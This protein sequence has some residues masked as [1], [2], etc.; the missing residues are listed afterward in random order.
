M[1]A[2]TFGLQ[3][4][5][6]ENLTMVEKLLSLCY[7]SNERNRD[8]V[9]FLE[10]IN[11]PRAAWPAAG[12]NHYFAYGIDEKWRESPGCGAFLH[13]PEALERVAEQ[14]GLYP[15]SKD[16]IKERLSKLLGADID[17]Y[18]PKDK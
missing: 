16:D 7:L 15:V 12:R 8:L 9:K 13:D 4:V 11:V 14:Y 6:R 1:A 2:P 3:R 18:S 5:P 17:D 10:G